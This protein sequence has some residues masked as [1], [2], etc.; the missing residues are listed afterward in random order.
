VKNLPTSEMSDQ[1]DSGHRRLRRHCMVILAGRYDIAHSH[2]V[3]V[4]NVCCAES[5]REVLSEGLVGR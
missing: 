2:G 4:R 3:A 1:S 5:V